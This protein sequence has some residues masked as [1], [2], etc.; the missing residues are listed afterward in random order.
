[1]T[2]TL[3]VSLGIAAALHAGAQCVPNPLY[4]DSLYG[5]W[6][7]TTENFAGGMVGVFYSDTLN[8]MVPSNASLINPDYPAFVTIDS[9]SLDQVTGLP[10]GIQVACNSQTNAPCTYLP[11]QLGCG[12]LE[13]TPTEAGTFD[14]VLNVTAY[15]NFLGPQAIPQSFSG[16]SITIVP[17]SVG[18]GD[19]KPLGT[20]RVRNVPNPFANRT[21]IEFDLSKPALATIKVF[22]LVGEQVWKETVQGKVGSNHVPFRSNDLENG[23]YLYHIEVAG[24]TRTGRMM[25]NR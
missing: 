24:T 13:G 9:I 22:N 23:I 16:Y 1:M 2:R 25:V 17:N 3:L 18:I 7:D 21:D 5:V 11:N 12:L 20:G 14:I 6:P 10:P 19:I 8:I 4:A 15:A